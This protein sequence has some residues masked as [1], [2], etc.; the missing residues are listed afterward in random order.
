MGISIAITTMESLAISGATAMAKAT[1]TT[2]TTAKAA[3]MESVAIPGAT[4]TAKASEP[5]MAVAKAAIVVTVVVAHCVGAEDL[6]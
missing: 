2:M 5:T 1:E 4:A 6:L 3:A